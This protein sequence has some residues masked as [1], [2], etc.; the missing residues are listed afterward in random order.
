MSMPLAKDRIEEAAELAK[1]FSKFSEALTRLEDE[2]GRWKNYEDDYDSLKST[3]LDLPKETSH[4]VMVPVGSLAFMSGKLIHTNEVLVMLGDNW[5]VDRSAAQAVEMNITKLRTQEDALRNKSGIAPGLLGG[6]EF[7]EEGLPIV[8]ITEPYYSDDEEPAITKHSQPSLLA[9]SQKSAKE[10]AEDQAILQRLAELERED[11]ERERRREA[12][13]VVTSDEDTES[14]D[15]DE[16]DDGASEDEFRP[17]ALDSDEEYEEEMWERSCNEDDDDDDQD[18]IP[19]SDPSGKKAVRFADQ[20]ANSSKASAPALSVPGTKPKSPADLFNQMRAKQQAVRSAISNERMVNMANLE[21]T[22][23]G[24]TTSSPAPHGKAPVF[25]LTKDTVEQ[26]ISKELKSA[27]KPTT[28]SSL[29]KQGRR[30]EEVKSAPLKATPVVGPVVPKPTSPPKKRSKFALARQT[31]ITTSSTGQ[32]ESSTTS[33]SADSAP[34]SRM[35]V[36]DTVMERDTVP[37]TMSMTISQSEPKQEQSHSTESTASLKDVIENTFTKP[38]AST[39]VHDT[40]K[41]GDHMP[42]SG[43]RKK[44]LFRQQHAQGHLDPEPAV[45]IAM[46]MDDDAYSTSTSQRINS[47][48][49]TRDPMNTISEGAPEVYQSAARVNYPPSV[50]AS[51][52]QPNRTGVHIGRSMASSSRTIPVIATSKLRD[53]ALMKGAIVETQHV[54]PIDEDELEDD[55]LMRQERRQAMIAKHGAFS[56][57]DV[58]RIWEQQ[59]VIPEGMLIPETDDYSVIG[60]LSHEYDAQEDALYDGESDDKQLQEIPAVVTN[61]S[62]VR[63]KKLSLFRA[64]RLTGSL[65]KQSK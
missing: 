45:P 47:S 48:M 26:S 33:T 38:K 4:N 58:E 55:M 17:K 1:Y 36:T 6:Q 59:V 62:N 5:F 19:Y 7:N 51:I 39:M 52:K 65:A 9:S 57:E 40:L 29:F 49:A 64:A 63:P 46:I 22:F 27:L 31:A 42:Q 14:E 10:Q 28:K 61:D 20:L 21:S 2:L 53:T 41:D 44:S 12:G 43:Q 24:L 15:E 25:E 30:S 60:E 16:Y 18:Q 32:G 50:V 8:D 13:E 34:K 37:P 23:A 11:E 56:R 35:G 3:L 54:E